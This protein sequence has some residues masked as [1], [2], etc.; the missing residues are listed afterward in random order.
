MRKKNGIIVLLVS[1]FV[2]ALIGFGLY[3]HRVNQR[4]EFDKLFTDDYKVKIDFGIV[5]REK[6]L[7]ETNALFKKVNQDNYYFVYIN[8]DNTIFAYFLDWYYAFDPMQGYN[9]DYKDKLKSETV[10][11]IMDR[12]KEISVPDLNSKVKDDYIEIRIDDTTSYV[13]RKEVQ[14][15]FQ[16]NGIILSIFK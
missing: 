11:T 9:L 12:L 2:L 10:N 1:F 4:A 16:D 7:R 14:Y 3:I 8:A 13:P 6:L 15:L 5:P